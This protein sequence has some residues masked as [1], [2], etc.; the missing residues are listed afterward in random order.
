MSKLWA[1]PGQSAK[2][3]P[4]TQ[5]T[6]AGGIAWLPPAVRAGPA[7]RTGARIDRA[8]MLEAVAEDF[9]KIPLS[10]MLAATVA[11]GMDYARAQN[12]RTMTLEHLL[13]A[14]T[15]DEEA[16]LVLIGCSVDLI[17][18][19]DDIAGFLGQLTDRSPADA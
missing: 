15:E 8:G 17:R 12:H 13:L 19:R 3:S 1:V 6:C 7:M 10:Q 2:L 11:R 18:L 4:R 9:G 14:L 5:I 16:A